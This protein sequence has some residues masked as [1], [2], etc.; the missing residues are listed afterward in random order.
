MN[1]YV[2]RFK[3]LYLKALANELNNLDDR[4]IF[5]TTY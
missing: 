3:N 1:S 4:F 5:R 2:E